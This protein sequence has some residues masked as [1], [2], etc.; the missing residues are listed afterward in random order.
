MLKRRIKPE[1]RT[2]WTQ[3]ER[4]P[5]VQTRIEP[6]APPAKVEEPKRKPLIRPFNSDLYAKMADDI[7][8]SGGLKAFEKGM[9]ETREHCNRRL[10]GG[11]K[12]EV[13]RANTR[14]LIERSIRESERII[15]S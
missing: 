11:R 1:S 14:R 9:K 15:H 12:R 3:G 8:M 13:S 4:E 7:L 5:A 6:E 2:H 10:V